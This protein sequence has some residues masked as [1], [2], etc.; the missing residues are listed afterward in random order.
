[1]NLVL[2]MMA[3]KESIEYTFVS[4]GQ[5]YC[6]PTNYKSNVKTFKQ[7]LTL[8]LNETNIRCK[9]KMKP[10]THNTEKYL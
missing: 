9:L 3:S 5:V 6:Q 7:H 10:T 1:M 4:H 2:Q 8:H